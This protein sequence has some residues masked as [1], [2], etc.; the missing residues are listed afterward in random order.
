MSSTISLMARGDAGGGAKDGGQGVIA[1]RLR[2]LQ[3]LSSELARAVT[4]D[5]VA[6]AAVGHGMAGTG[7]TSGV[8]AV[9]GKGGRSFELLGA[10][11]PETALLAPVDPCRIDAHVPLAMVARCGAPVWLSSPE[12]YEMQYPRLARRQGKAAVACYPLARG[13]VVWGALGFVWGAEQTFGPAEQAFI[14]SL[15]RHCLDALERASIHESE[16]QSRKVA[17][18]AAASLERL[19]RVTAALSRASDVTQVAEVVAR[20]GLGGTQAKACFVATW[21]EGAP[22]ILGEAAVAPDALPRARHAFL[23]RHLPLVAQTG[24]PI[25][26][27]REREGAPSMPLTTGFA[28]V[29]L[30]VGDRLLGALGFRLTRSRM[31][32]QGRIFMRALAELC[33]QAIDRARLYEAEREARTRAERAVRLKDEF[34]GIVSHE[35]RTPLTAISCWVALLRARQPDNLEVIRA[36]ESIERNTA[37]QARLV[38]D[39]LDASRI[40]SDKLLLEVDEVDLAL[41]LEN[42]REALAQAAQSKGV[43]LHVRLPE[44]PGPRVRGDA[45]RLE[46]V[47]RN[48]LSN[49][50][51]FTPSGG[52]VEARLHFLERSARVEVVDTGEGITS[53]FLPHVFERFRQADATAARR[54][55]GLG[56][57]LSIVKYLV[58]THGGHVRAE[59]QGRGKGAKLVVELPFGGPDL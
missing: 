17:E 6:R 59:S 26:P 48:L 14:A 18:N 10:L 25:W 52:T 27:D 24:E 36:L 32:E 15:C 23:G 56:L 11:G 12:A 45:V 49:A 53:E 16:R 58:E 33:G 55:G 30:I 57:G 37:I 22:R 35:L 42:A 7:A 43:H 44:A 46:Q 51:Q 29:P 31:N 2:R 4:A 20:E 8:L 41:V 39:L 50:I 9:L 34:L 1:E 38:E 21:Q 3:A 40:V 5:D 47:F 19:Q 13:G 28:C 54:H